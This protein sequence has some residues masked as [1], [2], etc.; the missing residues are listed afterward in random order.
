M[1]VVVTGASGF[2]G[3]N[4]LLRSPRD[5]DVVALYHRTLHLPDFVAA[6]RL[7]HV[8]AMQCDLLNVDDVMAVARAVGGRADAVMYLAANGDPAV[9]VER[10]KWDLQSNAVAVVNFLEHCPA[11]HLVYASSGAVYDGL[12]GGVSP[13][14]AIEP[15]LPYAIS[16]LAAER[17]IRFFTER[18]GELKGYVNARLFGAYGPYEAERKI[19]TRLLRSIMSGGREVVVRGD[20]KNLIDF[21]YIDDAVD[22]LLTLLRASGE[23]LTVDFAGGAPVSVNDVVEAIG[24]VMGVPLVVRHEGAVPEY[25]QFHSIDTTMRDRFGVTPKTPFD[26]GM[27]RFK[28]FFESERLVRPSA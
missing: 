14:V 1:K 11:D 4:I 28:A 10:P 15:E 12:S 18:R 3:K 21:M 17:Y 8:R 16:K 23:R 20:G 19:T 13:G 5:W 9:S 22:G 24:R 27:R 2:I 6:H 7:S 26:E 25:I